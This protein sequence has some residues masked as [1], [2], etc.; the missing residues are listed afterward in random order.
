[1]RIIAAIGSR[2]QVQEDLL[3]Q[4][5][6]NTKKRIIAIHVLLTSGNPSLTCLHMSGSVCMY[7]EHVFPFSSGA[8]RRDRVCS[9]V[10]AAR[11]RRL[12]NFSLPV[13]CSLKSCGKS[14]RGNKNLL[15]FARHITNINRK[16]VKKDLLWVCD[17]VD[18]LGS[19]SLK[20][21]GCGGCEGGAWCPCVT[22]VGVD[23]GAGD[24]CSS[25][26]PE[27]WMRSIHCT[28]SSVM[29]QPPT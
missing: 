15:F 8:A 18:Y 25:S 29:P 6:F 13:W 9:P 27:F 19:L 26:T 21:F 28:T 1:M 23:P 20:L 5:R 16:D 3:I 10:F 4:I 7:R 11:E 2:Q 12:K 17:V 22:V 14:R 24:V